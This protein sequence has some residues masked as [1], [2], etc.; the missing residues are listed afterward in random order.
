MRTVAPPGFNLSEFFQGVYTFQRWEIFPGHVTN[1]LK[2]VV[3]TM[4]RLEVPAHLEGRRVSDIAPWNG[5]FSFE[6]ARRGASEVVSLGPD[7]PGIT[8]YYKVRELLGVDNCEYI[9]ASLYDLDPA[10]HGAFDTVLFLG[11]IYH[12]RHLLL[13]L[14]KIYDVAVGDLYVDGPMLDGPHFAQAISGRE[15]KTLGPSVRDLPLAYFTKGAETGDPYN[16]FLL[17]R[18]GFRDFVESSGFNVVRTSDDR[19][20]W[21]WLVATKGERSFVPGVEGMNPNVANFPPNDG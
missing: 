7:D 21:A 15:F 10:A 5:F 9:R 11:V 1:G 14:D 6:C 3:Q 16:W 12:L 2:N 8:G 4:E 20:V 19:D 13:A 18:L 17:N